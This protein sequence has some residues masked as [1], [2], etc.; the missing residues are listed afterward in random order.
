MR[1]EGIMDRPTTPLSVTSYPSLETSLV[2][3]KSTYSPR[4]T[5]ITPTQNIKRLGTM[6]TH[7]I[8]DEADKLV[9]PKNMRRPNPST[10]SAALRLSTASLGAVRRSETPNSTMTTSY[11]SALEDDR[12]DEDDDDDDESF[13]RR[14]VPAFDGPIHI[15]ED[16][17]SNSSEIATYAD[18]CRERRESYDTTVYEPSSA[19]SSPQRSRGVDDSSYHFSSYLSPP[20]RA[21]MIRNST[22][23]V[24]QSAPPSPK[25]AP[26]EP[27]HPIVTKT[28]LPRLLSCTSAHFSLASS[29]STLRS[30]RTRYCTYTSIHTGIRCHAPTTDLQTLCPVHLYHAHS[31]GLSRNSLDQLQHRRLRRDDSLSKAFMTNSQWPFDNET[32]QTARNSPCQ[33]P[34]TRTPARHSSDESLSGNVLAG[35][36]I[37]PYIADSDGIQTVSNSPTLLIHPPPNQIHLPS[38]AS[39]Q[40]DGYTMSSLATIPSTARST[41]ILESGESEICLGYPFVENDPMIPGST[42]IDWKSNESRRREYEE[43]DRRRKGL[44][45][46]V[47]RRI[48]S[49]CCVR[50]PNEFWEGGPDDD[51]KGD[52][53]SVR[54][55]RL[56]LP[57]E[58][59]KDKNIETE[60]NGFAEVVIAAQAASARAS[61][62]EPA[63]AP[64]TAGGVRNSFA[65][66]QG[67][68]SEGKVVR[69]ASVAGDFGWR[70]PALIPPFKDAPTVS[71]LEKVDSH[72]STDLQCYTPG[73]DS[74]I[75][76]SGQSSPSV[77]RK[78]VSPFP[79]PPRVVGK[80]K[81]AG[82][83]SML[84][85]RRKKVERWS[86][87]ATIA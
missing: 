28:P 19:P 6:P 52:G 8:L 73:H 9:V 14:I 74:L 56:V 63:S 31:P 7:E 50:D 13:I 64:S 32:L 24:T 72:G 79:S 47:R 36:A 25:Q 33:T 58:R 86:T 82:E 41:S 75:F 39:F 12:D 51:T 18:S 60:P 84:F 81:S 66:R 55:Y 4:L 3:K 22:S 83:D 29:S 80:S 35:L 53:G 68:K 43:A 15:Q 87:T 57:E 61:R 42:V 65:G 54:R 1:I 16:I 34:Y 11:Y 69:R 30:P 70:G 85:W 37:S 76:R 27:S 10:A 48:R 26:A 23:L 44:W 40:T 45:G 67:T 46:W 2:D 17:G 62:H 5:P 77:S 38:R 21:S 71:V 78:T 49:L 59:Q 20:P